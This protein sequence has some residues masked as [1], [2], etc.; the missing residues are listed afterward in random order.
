MTVLIR[1]DEWK[2]KKLRR[3]CSSVAVSG[4][5]RNIVLAS[6]IWNARPRQAV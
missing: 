2:R 4:A 6:E 5:A 1:D 3:Q